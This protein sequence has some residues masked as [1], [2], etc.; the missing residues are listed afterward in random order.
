[1]AFFLSYY[2]LTRT[3]CLC[4]FFLLTI[5][6]RHFGFSQLLW[7]KICFC[8]LCFH[9]A[10]GVN[11]YVRIC[12]CV[13]VCVCAAVYTCS[14]DSP[15]SLLCHN[16]THKHTHTHAVAPPLKNVRKRRFRKTAPKKVCVPLYLIPG[17]KTCS[18][19]AHCKKKNS[20]H[21]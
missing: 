6:H 21:N 17:A 1:M 19:L 16:C 8:T 12:V 3:C 14:C 11:V 15:P 18:F 9:L 4:S 13:C 2:T 7:L 20:Q 10:Y 5:E